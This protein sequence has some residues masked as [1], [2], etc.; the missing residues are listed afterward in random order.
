MDSKS[1]TRRFLRI[2]VVVL[3]VLGGVLLLVVV[4]LVAMTQTTAGRQRLAREAQRHLAAALPQAEVRIEEIGGNLLRSPTI[5]GLTVTHE[6]TPVIR[7]ERVDVRYDLTRLLR[8]DIAIQEVV[9]NEPVITVERGAE[10]I[11]LFEAFSREQSPG[12]PA[13]PFQI[14]TIVLTDGS[15]AVGPNVDTLDAIDVP[16]HIRDLDARL[17]LSRD[18][19]GFHID[20]DALSFHATEPELAGELEGGIH[21]RSDGWALEEV[22]LRTTESS[23]RLDGAVGNFSDSGGAP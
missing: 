12:A 21:R 2:A 8:G 3:A 14:D 10:G 15:V 17:G 1:P 20:I 4:L 19:D 13:R 16:N 5:R 6:G 7:A 23:I 22:R 9:I 18:K 11:G